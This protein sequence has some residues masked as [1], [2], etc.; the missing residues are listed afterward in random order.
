MK[1]RK[2]WF[3]DIDVIVQ[4]STH[5]YAETEDEAYKKAHEDFMK[6]KDFPLIDDVVY[7]EYL[8]D[9]LTCTDSR[10]ED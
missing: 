7:G 2:I 8:F 1:K 5:V 6:E 4:D 9:T 10:E 3:F